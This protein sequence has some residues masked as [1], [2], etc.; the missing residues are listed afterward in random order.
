MVFDAE[1]AHARHQAFA[2]GL[3]LI[4]NQ[5]GMRCAEHD[6]DRIRAALQN[7][8]H[9]VDHD[10]DALVGRQQ[11][12]CQNDRLPAKSELGLRRIGLDKRNVGNAVGNDFDLVVRHLIDAAQQLAA[13]V[14]HH[15]DLRRRLDD[16]LHHRALSGRRLG[17][18]GMERRHHRHGEARQQREDVGAGFA[19]ENSEFVLQANG[20]EPAGVQEVGRAHVLFDIV[21]LDLQSDRRRIVVGLTVIG[22]R[23]DAGL[24]VRA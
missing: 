2:I 12:E 3:A 24:Q 9:G 5:I 20:V 8:R 22:H 1:F 21:V 19:A 6:I 17:Q 18:H 16:A 23:H 11:A 7:R 13:L 14:G 4:S 15:H 10:F